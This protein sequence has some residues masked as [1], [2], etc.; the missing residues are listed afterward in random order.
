MC[1]SVYMYLVYSTPI[2]AHSA[3]YSET[4]GLCLRNAVSTEVLQPQISPETL[5]QV[6][7]AMKTN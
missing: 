5:L 4:N 1:V 3:N 6:A 2:S 7:E